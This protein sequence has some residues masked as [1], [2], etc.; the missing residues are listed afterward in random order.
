MLK[1]A[2]SSAFCSYLI[3]LE[4]WRRGLTLKYYSEKVTKKNIHAPG[5][6]YTLSSDTNTH[7]FYK[8]RG[9]RVKEQAFS[10][11]SN[12]F[13]T[14]KWLEKQGIPVVEGEKFG[15]DVPD[16]EIIDYA[17]SLGYPVVLK[18]VV[19]AQGKGVIAN[20]NTTEYLEKSLK[21]VRNQLNS[22]DVIIEKHFEGEEYRLYVIEDEV[23]AVMN[24]IPANIIGDGVHTIGELIKLK[25]KERKKNPRLITCLIK[26]DFEV[27][28]TL[29]KRGHTLE[30]KLAKGQQLFLRENSNIS[31]GGDSIE[32]TDYFPEEVKK[33]AVAALKSI[34]NF[35]HGGVDI[36]YNKNK[37][38]EESAV[39]IELSPTPQ[40]GSLVFPMKGVS[41]DVPSAIIDYYFPEVKEKKNVNSNIYFNLSAVLEPLINKTASEVTVSPPPSNLIISKK[42]IV[43]GEVQRVGYRKWVRKK[44]I[45]LDL[46]GYAK[47]L[48]NGNVEIVVAGTENNINLFKDKCRKGPKASKVET[49]SEEISEASLKVGFEILEEPKK[50]QKLTINNSN[51]NGQVKKIKSISIKR[52]LK[53]LL[54]KK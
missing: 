22:S 2:Q 27:L 47:N 11:G 24:R 37:T 33:I 46:I 44:A 14:K 36:I 13:A 26:K 45:E 49:V 25:N 28:N 54:G 35:P 48:L 52:F 3:A 4:G 9:D 50:K 16:Y 8:A 40:I 6:L 42:M 18:P 30:S 7:R 12:K 41:R 21:Y 51:N 43:V 20:I 39:V 34:P 5:L 19:G 38:G 29:E 23:I 32:V 15:K 31:T 53:R 17:N 10:I 1:D